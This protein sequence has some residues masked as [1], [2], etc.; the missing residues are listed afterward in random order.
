MAPCNELENLYICDVPEEIGRFTS[1]HKG[2][3]KVLFDA[4]EWI[5]RIFPDVV[6]LHLE[7]HQDPEEDSEGL[8]VVVE[9]SL[10]PKNLLIAWISLMKNGFW[11][12]LFSRGLYLM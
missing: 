12:Y 9:T 4:H 10:P 5:M 6:N 1:N 3:A 8:F 11:K 7:L 2:L